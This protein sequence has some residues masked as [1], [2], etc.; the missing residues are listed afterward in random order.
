MTTHNET[1]SVSAISLSMDVPLEVDVSSEN[2]VDP[3]ALILATAF[4]EKVGGLARLTKR[5]GDL[6]HLYICTMGSWASPKVLADVSLQ[7][8]FKQILFAL[9]HSLRVVRVVEAGRVLLWNN[10]KDNSGN[11]IDQGHQGHQ[12]H[13]VQGYQ[14]RGHQGQGY[15]GQGYQGHSVR[16]HSRQGH[17]GQGHQGHSVRGHSG[18][19]HSGHGHQGHS[20][21][22][23]HRQ[24]HQHQGHSVEGQQKPTERRSRYQDGGDGDIRPNSS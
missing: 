5:R 16:G 1:N 21:Q 6:S 15:Q 13:S 9:A 23:H 11:N 2:G 4:M 10:Y 3:Q 8:H 7:R 22:G 12:G 14:G 20:G 19:G 24:G 17:Q 18:Q